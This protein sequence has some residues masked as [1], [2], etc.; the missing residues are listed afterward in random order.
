MHLTI[1]PRLQCVTNLSSV[2]YCLDSTG[3]TYPPCLYFPLT[4]QSETIEN[5]ECVSGTPVSL[6][7][8][9]AHFN[10]GT[11]CPLHGSSKSGDSAVLS[12]Y[13]VNFLLY[14]SNIHTLFE[15]LCGYVYAPA[16]CSVC[17][18]RWLIA[19]EPALSAPLRKRKIMT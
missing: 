10:T 15:I 7:D 14:S 12:G 5:S 6:L 19:S 2:S 3:F 1:E 9:G 11:R 8:E 17:S 13:R 18:I 16:Y 4:F